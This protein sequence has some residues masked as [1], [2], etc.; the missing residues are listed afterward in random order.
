[1]A[2]LTWGRILLAATLVALGAWLVGTLVDRAGSTPSEIPIAVVPLLVVLSGAT[3]W[4][5][6]KVRQYR[7]G[8]RPNLDPIVAAR[9][10]MFSQ[11]AAY[12]GAAL[13]GGYLG[14][15]LAFISYWSHAPRR[16]VVVSAVIAAG[17]GVLLCAAGWIAERWCDASGGDDDPPNSSSSAVSGAKG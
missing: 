16:D 12:S 3:L 15:G 2:R 4:W 13:V 1:M 9:I 8:N 10:A 5:G 17:A 7:A 14:Y 11:A 6:W